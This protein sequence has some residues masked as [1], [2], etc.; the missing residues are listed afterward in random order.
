MMRRFLN[1][2]FWEEKKRMYYWIYQ[3]K[4]RLWRGWQWVDTSNLSM[5]SVYLVMTNNM[6]VNMIWSNS[7]LIFVKL[8]IILFY[9]VRLLIAFSIGTVYSPIKLRKIAKTIGMEIEALE[10][11]S[12]MEIHSLL[13][14]E[15][16]NHPS[17][18]RYLVYA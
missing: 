1:H 15:R 17:L 14:N 10:V 13:I 16:E 8:Q 2:L 5:N 12:D 3:R 4:R 9:C 11:L 18:T 6:M 7:I